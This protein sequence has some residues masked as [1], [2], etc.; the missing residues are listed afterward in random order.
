MGNIKAPNSIQIRGGRVHN[1]KNID[2]DV[3]LN[4]IV[5]IAEFPVRKCFIGFG[6]PF[7]PEGPVGIWSLCPRNT[8]RQNAAQAEKAQVDEVL[9]RSGGIGTSS[10]SRGSGDS[11]HFRDRHGTSEHTTAD[12]LGGWQ[13]TAVPMV[14][15]FLRL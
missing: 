3:P 10:T 8:R 14:T 1:L 15:I 13:A 2:V 9:L 11:Q 12:V 4:R 6:N 7:R 5:G